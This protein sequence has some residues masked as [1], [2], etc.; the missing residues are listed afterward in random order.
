MKKDKDSKPLP[1]FKTDEEAENFVDTADL[2]EYDLSGF[3]PLSTFDFAKKKDAR[4]EVRLSQDDLNIL[5][6]AAKI[7][8]IPYTRL[9][10]QLMREGLAQMPHE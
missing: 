6:E 8:G 7:K 10:R 3:R 2:S 1:V 9:A 5:K 4:L